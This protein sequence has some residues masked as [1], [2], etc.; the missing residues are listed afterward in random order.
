MLKP[1]LIS[2]ILTL[3][4][5]SA[6]YSTLTEDQ[7]N[8]KIEKLFRKFKKDLRKKYFDKY[9]EGKRLQ[10]FK[11]RIIESFPNYLEAD[12][13]I[14][15]FNNFFDLTKKEFESKFLVSN[16]VITQID[17]LFIRDYVLQSS[18]DEE[19]LRF[20][21]SS[22]SLNFVFNS[23]IIGP[24][25]DEQAILSNYYHINGCPLSYAISVVNSISS[26]ATY[27]YVLPSYKRGSISQLIDCAAYTNNDIDTICYPNRQNLYNFIDLNGYA[28]ELSYPTYSNVDYCRTNNPQTTFLLPTNVNSYGYSLPDET[29]IKKSMIKY[30]PLA[31]YFTGGFLY[32][33]TGQIITSH[34]QCGDLWYFG[35][36]IGWEENATTRY[37]LIKTSLNINNGATKIVKIKIDGNVCGVMSYAMYPIFAGVNYSNA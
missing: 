25:Y 20:L 32:T 27:K 3:S 29:S 34:N 13:D 33:Y 1:L 12:F 9:E 10:I 6:I 37:W 22:G 24:Y 14:A 7:V 4:F 19:P 35:L 2:I 18:D 23:T 36:L 5:V 31:V 15:Q 30:G 17:S 16:E 28:T 26:S 8:D 11:D 21:Q